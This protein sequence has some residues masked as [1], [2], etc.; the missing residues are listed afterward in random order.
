MTLRGAERANPA[1]FED[2]EPHRIQ[3]RKVYAPMLWGVINS[4]RAPDLDDIGR[5]V[6]ADLFDRMADEALWAVTEIRDFDELKYFSQRYISEAVRT[7]WAGLTEANAKHKYLYFKGAN[8]RV[9]IKHEHVVPRDHLKKADRS[10]STARLAAVPR[11]ARTATTNPGETSTERQPA[12]DR[13][14]QP[15][16]LTRSPAHSPAPCANA[17]FFDLSF[18][19]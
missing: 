15:T 5:E 10:A 3:I 12:C 17:P 6:A 16:K 7:R 18:R 13:P 9:D 11:G 14:R 19:I 1:V 2:L 8:G 4:M